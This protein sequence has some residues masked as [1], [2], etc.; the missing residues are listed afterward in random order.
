MADD[1]ARRGRAV[2]PL[3]RVDPEGQVVATPDDLRRDD[4]LPEVVVVRRG[5]R[6]D[7]RPGLR[8]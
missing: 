6:V 1:L 2:R 3:D 5:R 8:P 4:R 7:A